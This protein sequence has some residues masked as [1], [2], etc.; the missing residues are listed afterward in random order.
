MQNINRILIQLDRAV[1]LA[2]SNLSQEKALSIILFDNLIELQLYKRMDFALL[3]DQTTWFAGKRSFNKKEREE[4][5]GP[6]GKYDRLLKLAMD[7]KIIKLDEREIIQFAHEIRNA[8]YHRWEEDKLK[9][10]LAILIYYGFIVNRFKVWGSPS[11]LTGYTDLP[12][13]QAIDFGQGITDID[14]LFDGE[15]YFES[16]LDAIMSK[17]KITNNLA[18]KAHNVVMDQIK[19]IE[20]GLNFIKTDGLQVNYYGALSRYWY[21]NDEFSKFEYQSR[22][23]KGVDRILLLSLY[24]RRNKDYLADIPELETRQKEGRRLLRELGQEYKGKYPFWSDLEQI[25]RRIAGFQNKSTHVIIKNLMD[26]QNKI[27]NL[28]LDVEE[29]SSNLDGYVQHL[30]DVYRGK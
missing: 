22:K 7:V 24:I 8:V 18:E 20:Q 15:K 10:D 28:Y 2:N 6:R 9:L 3:M 11:G 5:V 25:K 27:S 21:L 16:A 12:E 23:P 19:Q 29:A 1:S 17:W 13:Y 14:I 26:I 30:L 4:A